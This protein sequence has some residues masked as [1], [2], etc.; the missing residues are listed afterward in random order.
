[1]FAAVLAL[2][3]PTGCSDDENRPPA[4]TG[5][6]RGTLTQVE[7]GAPVIGAKLLLVDPA[8]L[9]TKS[10]FARTNVIGRYRIDEVEP[11]TYAVFVFHDTL[12]IYQRSGPLV[13]VSA[14]AISVHNVSLLDS[15]FNDHTGYRVAGNVIDASTREPIAGAYVEGIFSGY[16]DVEFLFQAYGGPYWAVTDEDGSFS[17]RVSSLTDEQGDPRGLEPVSAAK[18]GYR[19]GTLVGSGPSDAPLYPALLPLP[20]EEDSILT[21][22][23]RLEPEGGAGPD[24]ASTGALRGQARFLGDPVAGLPVA[25]SLTYVSDPDTMP[26]GRARARVPVP[27]R[28]TI[29]DAEG[30]FLIPGLTPG[31]YVVH[32]AYQ[33]GDG[34]LFEWV[35][36]FTVAAAETVEVGLPSLQIAIR[37]LGPEDGSVITDRTPEFRWE[38][39]PDAA[40]YEFLGYRL[41]YATSHF[42]WTI[43]E[44]LDG[45]S[46]Q[47]PDASAFPPGASIRWNVEVLGRIEGDP[48][49][50]VARFEH[51]ATFQ[52]AR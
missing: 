23:L 37:P 7:N 9:A 22:L 45:T 42:D 2:A 6:V 5:S 28:T 15:Q 16:N 20:Q 14:G 10:P 17:V 21:V 40:G 35:N 41:S 11:G 44:P 8:T 24:P 19:P 52:I 4:P 47:L 25:A 26:G 30:R 49:S 27:D 46:W 32:P 29:T 36:Q 31:A 38:P 3:G 1:M 13:R 50:V 18:S 12:L 51:L 43:V 33:D 34:Y 48:N 39:R